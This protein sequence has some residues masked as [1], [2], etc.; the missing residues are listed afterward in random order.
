MMCAALRYTVHNSKAE[1][2]LGTSL[3]TLHAGIG[4][5][6]AG[7]PAH[8]TARARLALYFGTAAPREGSGSGASSP[9]SI[10]LPSPRLQDRFTHPSCGSA[11]DAG[12]VLSLASLASP[13]S[14]SASSEQECDMLFVAA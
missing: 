3:K 13:T 2:V 6:R 14:V 11:A 10:R 7:Q 12:T 8:K 9:P 4:R 1:H 5:T